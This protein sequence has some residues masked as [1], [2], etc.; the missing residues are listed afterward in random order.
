MKGWNMSREATRRGL[1]SEYRTIHAWVQR[2]K[3]KPKRCSQCGK[4]GALI[5]WA[6]VD[7]KYRK[8]PEDY[9]ALC[10]SCHLEKDMPKKTDNSYFEEKV[11]LRIDNL[12]D[13][14]PIRVL[15]MYSGTGSIWDHI[16]AHTDKNIEV[17]A[18]E[19]RDIKGR[20][21][22]HGDNS[23]YRLD[24]DYFD[25]IDLDAYGV[26]FEQLEDVFARCRAKM[27]IHVTYIQSQYGRLPVKMLEAIGYTRPMVKKIPTLFNKD[28]QKKFLNYLAVRGVK[29]IKIY[30]TV[31]HRKTYATF[32]INE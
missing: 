10:Q 25:V 20:I 29:N 31:N 22:L 7:H 28:G 5:Q 15:D 11:K 3:G 1:T 21:Y 24:Y 18:I 13:R 32:K 26:P 4:A 17:L 30:D 23:K 16:K 6:N 8:R 2:V 27:I 19:K 12:P 9:V 14:N